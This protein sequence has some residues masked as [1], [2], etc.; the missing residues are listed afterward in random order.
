MDS[1]FGQGLSDGIPGR[2]RHQ[3]TSPA[4]AR[5]AMSNAW[6]LHGSEIR[7]VDLGPLYASP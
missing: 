5:T 3:N 2:Q 7:S 1:G 4:M 6:R